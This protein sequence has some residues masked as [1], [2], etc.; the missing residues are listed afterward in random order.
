MIIE[1]IRRK[2]FDFSDRIRGLGFVTDDRALRIGDRL[3]AAPYA[4][5]L[6]GGVYPLYGNSQP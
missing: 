2:S 1:L 6:K 4:A 5:V 3:I